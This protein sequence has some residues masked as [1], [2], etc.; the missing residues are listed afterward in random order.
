MLLAQTEA[1]VSKWYDPSKLEDY[2]GSLP[3]FRNR[4]NLVIQYKNLREKVPRELRFAIVIQRL[5]LQKRILLRRNEWL[6]RELRSVFS[7]KIQL[8]S[9]LESLEKLLNETRNETINLIRSSTS[10]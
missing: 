9:E 5:Y 4:L 8:E 7:E 1:I 6:T 3:K 10:E 2:L